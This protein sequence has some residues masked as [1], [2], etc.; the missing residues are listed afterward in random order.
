M[1]AAMTASALRAT[2]R[3]YSTRL[4][5]SSSLCSFVSNHVLS[6]KRFIGDPRPF[7]MRHHKP[8]TVVNTATAYVRHKLEPRAARTRNTTL[9]PANR[10]GRRSVRIAHWTVAGRHELLS[11]LSSSNHRRR[12]LDNAPRPRYP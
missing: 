11:T 9:E 6:T 2:R 1:T 4:A 10:L 12:E 7:S 5:P 8:R 3:M